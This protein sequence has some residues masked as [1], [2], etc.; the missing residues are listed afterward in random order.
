MSRRIANRTLMA[1]TVALLVSVV[2]LPVASATAPQAPDTEQVN[3][4][5]REEGWENSQVMRTLHFLTDRYG[6]RLT[7]SPNY[8]NA[9]KWAIQQMEDWGFANAHLEGWDFGRPG[10]LNER[11]SVHMIAPVKDALVGEVLA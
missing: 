11:F 10:W 6:P 4:K 5:I 1:T 2:L 3:A 8:E 9:A 7:G